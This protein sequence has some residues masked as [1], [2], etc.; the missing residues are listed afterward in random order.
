MKKIQITIQSHLGKTTHLQ[1]PAY[2]AKVP[3]LLEDIQNGQVGTASFEFTEAD[4][5]TFLKV[6]DKQKNRN[7]QAEVTSN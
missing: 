6:K 2:L 4:N 5:I 3:H 1:V 7:Q